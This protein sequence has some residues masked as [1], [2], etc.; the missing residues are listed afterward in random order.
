MA[1]DAILGY[2]ASHDEIP[3]SGLFA[4]QHGLHHNDVV[5]VIKSLHGFRYI[6]AQDI[7]RESWVLT[8]E[9]KK[10]A[11]EGS[12]EVQLF[13]AIPPE[14]Y[15]CKDELQASAELLPLLIPSHFQSCVF[16]YSLEI[17]LSISIIFL[18]NCK[19]LLLLGSVFKNLLKK[20][21]KSK[22]VAKC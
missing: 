21:K 10:Y 15:I 22:L 1:D 19:L 3:D 14:G 8:D 20:I 13:L 2:L 11:A 6:D 16:L 18:F 9:G 12:P 4:S 5:N 7:N 17:A